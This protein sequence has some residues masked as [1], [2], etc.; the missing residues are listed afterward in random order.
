LTIDAARRRN[1]HY[2]RGEKLSMKKRI[3]YGYDNS[4]DVDIIIYRKKG[5][6]TSE[7]LSFVGY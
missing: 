5:H 7:S 2:M 6:L 1:E 4:L 3:N